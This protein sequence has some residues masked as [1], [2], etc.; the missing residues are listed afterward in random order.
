MDVTFESFGTLAKVYVF[1]GIEMRYQ[2][3][4]NYFNK[5]IEEN[6][7]NLKLTSES[8]TINIQNSKYTEQ[9]RNYKK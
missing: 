7:L 4:R 1:D 9:K 5:I 6:F 8:D 3:C 2:R